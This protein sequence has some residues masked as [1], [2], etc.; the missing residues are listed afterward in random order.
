MYLFK[1]YDV[2]VILFKTAQIFQCASIPHSL[3]FIA[4][5]KNEIWCYHKVNKHFFFQ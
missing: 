3:A 5:V 2:S 4:A 1:S